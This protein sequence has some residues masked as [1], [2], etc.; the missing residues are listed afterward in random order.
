LNY[1]NEVWK[2]HPIHK[3]YY[4]SN[5]GRLKYYNK[6]QKKEIIKKQYAR[7]ITNRLVITIYNT[8]FECKTL[9]VPKFILECFHGLNEDLFT[10][11]ID[12]NYYN[13]N[14]ENLAYAT[15]QEIN[16]NPNVKRKEINYN[17][18][19]ESVEEIIQNETWKKHPTLEIEC[20]DKGRIKWKRKNETYHITYGSK[21]TCGYLRIQVNNKTYAV[22]RLICETFIENPNNK[23][24]VNHIDANPA[25]NNIE[26]LEWCT[27]R[28]NCM[29]EIT[30]KK[31]A[32]QIKSIDDNGIETIYKSLKDAYRYGFKECGIIRCCQ[33]LQNKHKGLRWQYV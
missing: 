18:Q 2:E 27:A 10:L 21:T 33:G 14:I 15:K 7:P 16:S 1:E 9:Y 30:Y 29:S 28:E 22:H 13:N 26:N 5:L 12:G 11:H 20:S 8:H 19:K 24:F 25:N 31:Q 17:K 4:A 3:G 23:P 6:Q 32:H